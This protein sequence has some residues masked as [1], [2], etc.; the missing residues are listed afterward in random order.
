[1]ERHKKTVI[2]T[3]RIKLLVV[4]VKDAGCCTKDKHIMQIFHYPPQKIN[5]H[6]QK[7]N[8]SCGNC[9][10]KLCLHHHSPQYIFMKK[11]LSLTALY[12]STAAP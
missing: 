9:F 1:M 8:G 5:D 3:L 6:P 10:K 4:M 12:C 11:S 7:I 2:K